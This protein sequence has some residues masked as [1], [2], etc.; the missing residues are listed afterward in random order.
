MTLLLYH[1]VLR[2]HHLSGS[3]HR[4]KKDN[5]KDIQRRVECHLE[6]WCPEG[7]LRTQKRRVQCLRCLE[8]A[9]EEYLQLLKKI[10]GIMDIPSLRSERNFVW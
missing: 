10:G 7:L 3:P 2:L 6:R 5:P 4:A 8:L 9:E 1:G